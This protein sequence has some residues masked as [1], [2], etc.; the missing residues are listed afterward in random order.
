MRYGLLASL[1]LFALFL[2]WAIVVKLDEG[3]VAVGSVAVESRK[4]TI[5]HLEGRI[6]SAVFV[7][8]G[9]DVEAGQVLIRLDA[10]QARARRDQAQS[11]L[12]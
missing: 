2:I 12:L 6:I 9:Q 3:V 1:G 8:E 10:T 4:K 5:Q 7:A 11:Q